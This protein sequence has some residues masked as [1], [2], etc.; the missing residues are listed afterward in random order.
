MNYRDILLTSEDAIKTYTNINDNIAGDYLLPA[1]NIAQRKGLESIL[2]SALVRKLQELVAEGTIVYEE[3][4]YYKELLDEYV[5]DYLSYASIVELI[6][7][8]S[9]KIGNIGTV[10]TEDEKDL[11]M[12]FNEVFK[13][14][15]YYEDEMEYFAVRMQKYLVENYSKFP[16]LAKY[17]SIEDM[18]PNLYSASNCNIFLGGARGKKI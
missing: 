18:R 3:N 7:I 13:L 4:S 9:F 15:D 5:S 14:K 16:E 12:S 2:G 11:S 10:R 6:P 1:I 17:K 8:V